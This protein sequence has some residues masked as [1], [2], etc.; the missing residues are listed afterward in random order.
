[1]QR[2]L[3]LKIKRLLLLFLQRKLKIDYIRASRLIQ[4]LEKEKVIGSPEVGKRF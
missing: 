1:M 3:L 2:E 4:Q